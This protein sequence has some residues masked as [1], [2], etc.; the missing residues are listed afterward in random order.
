MEHGGSRPGVGAEVERGPYRVRQGYHPILRAVEEGAVSFDLELEPS[1]T[2]LLVSGPNAGG[3]TVLLKALGL[4]SA[5]T[6]SGIV[7]PVGAGTRLPVFERF[8][9]IIGDE[10]S[11]EA[12]LSTF[13]A[14]V[15]ILREILER[16]DG[17]SLVLVDEIGSNTDPEEGAALD[18][19]GKPFEGMIGG[20]F[21]YTA[22]EAVHLGAGWEYDAL[23]G[24]RFGVE[25]FYKHLWDRAIATPNGQAPFYVTGGIGR[26]YGAEFSVNIRP[27]T[28]RHYFGYLS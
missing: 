8:F 17:R 26:I 13:S 15:G 10:Q 11:I 22:K 14:Q 2:V 27:A 24:A 12:S 1:E 18:F 9:A 7:P 3:K 19:M 28:G 4:I 21:I 20:G 6:Q 5:M 25:G 16:S 23:P